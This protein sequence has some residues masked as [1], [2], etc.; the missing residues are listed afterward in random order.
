MLIIR[1]WRVCSSTP[2]LSGTE[3]VK[4]DERSLAAANFKIYYYL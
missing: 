3:S 2:S 4:S 1:V